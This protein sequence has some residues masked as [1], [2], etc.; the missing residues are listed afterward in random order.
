MT[1]PWAHVAQATIPKYL[2]G[3][4]DATF[5]KYM[6]LAMLRAKGKVSYNNSGIR[7]E[8]PIKYRQNQMR[9]YEDGTGINFA[10]QNRLKRAVWPWAAYIMPESISRMDELQNRGTEALV[11]LF[12][13]KTETLM[14]EMQDQFHSQFYV[15]GTAAGFE[16]AIHGF[17]TFCG[18]SGTATNGYVGTNNSTYAGLSCALASGGG[19][20]ET[21]GGNTIW[22][23]GSGDPNYDFWT[24]MVLQYQATGWEI[25]TA[26]WDA[27]AESV[28]RFGLTHG[29]RNSSTEGMIDVI[30]LDPELYRKFKELASG[31]ERINV[32][33][34]EATSLVSLGFKNSMN[35]EG[36]EVTAEFGVPAGT[37]YGLNFD[38]MELH[39]QNEDL[40]IMKG[41]TYHEDHDAHLFF[42]AFNGQLRVQSPR[43]QFK[44][45]T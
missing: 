44:V 40:F 9:Q 2:P 43:D 45:R 20:W 19:T 27:R 29:M 28:L 18:I 23:R 24:P 16:N 36:A 6:M 11:N 42:L 5:R 14:T 31:K 33:R 12:S 32:Q 26:T 37:G 8:K 35:F 30:A 4:V 15:D 41:P 34:G 17:E 39:S 38:S 25:P 13:D 7:I 21:S 10:R 22:P 3:A 1:A